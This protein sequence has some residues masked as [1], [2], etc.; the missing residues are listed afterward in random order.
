MVWDM[1]FTLVTYDGFSQR[2][3]LCFHQENMNNMA[4]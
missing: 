3:K 4:N 1:A 2:L